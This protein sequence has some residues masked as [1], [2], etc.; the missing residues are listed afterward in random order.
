MGMSQITTH[1][2]TQTHAHPHAPGLSVLRGE[3][4]PLDW[5]ESAAAL[6]C[7]GAPAVRA[8][9][10]ETLAALA[11]AAPDDAVRGGGFAT[12]GATGLESFVA[13]R[14]AVAVAAAAAAAAAGA[15]LLPTVL[16]GAAEGVGVA[17]GFSGPLASRSWV[18]FV[19]RTCTSGRV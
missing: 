16:P 3:A 19:E 6:D 18:D 2:P 14:G 10:D 9:A 12:A 13:G 5:A 17:A 11:R 7:D 4:A 15:A 1:L 8:A